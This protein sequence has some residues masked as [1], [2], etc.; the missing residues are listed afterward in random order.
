MGS[1]KRQ[2]HHDLSPTMKTPLGSTLNPQHR[3]GRAAGNLH[4]N[5]ENEII[6]GRIQVE[7]ILPCMV[8]GS[9]TSVE[10]VVSKTLLIYIWAC[11]ALC[12]QMKGWDVLGRSSFRLE[13]P[14]VR[15]KTSAG[16][17]VFGA[18]SSNTGSSAGIA[19]HTGSVWWFYCWGSR[20]LHHWLM[21]LSG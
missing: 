13:E 6:Q 3:V 10:G 5:I 1:Y 11:K 18:A 2:L 12:A 4:S 19:L 15:C 9:D 16:R 14:G 8:R 7:N 17:L 20:L 21:H